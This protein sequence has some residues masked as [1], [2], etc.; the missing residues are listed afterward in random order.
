MTE[1]SNRDNAERER[2]KL[3]EDRKKLWAAIDG[4]E[5]ARQDAE[6]KREEAEKARALAAQKQKQDLQRFFLNANNI[7]DN[8]IA[9]NQS[10]LQKAFELVEEKF[11][12]SDT[13]QAEFEKQLKPLKET[14]DKIAWAIGLNN[15]DN[16]GGRPGIEITH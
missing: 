13:K 12:K 5:N 1:E 9:S 11:K 15:P 6:K 10:T 4:F 16:P 8:R 3:E 2:K 7:I 14:V